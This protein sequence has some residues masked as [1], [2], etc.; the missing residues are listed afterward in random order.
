MN[1]VNFL[2]SVSNLSYPRMVF[3]Y[4][5]YFLA[6]KNIAEIGEKI[7]VDN[8][9][10]NSIKFL[11]AVNNASEKNEIMRR[12]QSGIIDIY[13]RPITIHSELVS[14]KKILLEFL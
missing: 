12:A 6:L 7:S 1:R 9:T 14:N 5:D 8:A 13:G 10:N 11:V 2:N 4:Y 3:D